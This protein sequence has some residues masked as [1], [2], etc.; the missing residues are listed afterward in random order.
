MAADIPSRLVLGRVNDGYPK[1]PHGAPMVNTMF[2][3]RNDCYHGRCPHQ[4]SVRGIRGR[5]R[6][7]LP[8]GL[9]SPR[10]MG[11]PRWKWPG[12]CNRH[13]VNSGSA[14]WAAS[15]EPLSQGRLSR[16]GRRGHSG[17]RACS[18]G[19][20][21]RSL[22]SSPSC[23]FPGREGRREHPGLRPYD[24]RR[25]RGPCRGHGRYRGGNPCQSPSGGGGPD[26]GRRAPP[27]GTG[28]GILSP[29]APCCQ[30]VRMPP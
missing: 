2:K 19:R 10:S 27:L 3:E 7:A 13:K 9:Q 11:S 12:S 17:Y 20:R 24:R 15:D 30:T 5:E 14:S 8:E 6:A 16:G 23:P 1:P 29:P 18:R 28:E 25:L 21:D 22:R 4:E 26:G